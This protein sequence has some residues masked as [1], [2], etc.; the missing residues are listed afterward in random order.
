MPVRIVQQ[1]AVVR[2]GKKGEF[3]EDKKEGKGEMKIL[4]LCS[5]PSSSASFDLLL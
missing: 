1:S 5:S 3:D 2:M 4:S